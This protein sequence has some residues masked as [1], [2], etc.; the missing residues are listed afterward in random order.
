MECHAMADLD[1]FQKINEL[2][3]EEEQL[4]AS[5][6]DGSGLSEPERDR[7]EAIRVELD[8]T[9][10][11]LHQRQGRVDA[12]EDPESATVRSANVVENYEQ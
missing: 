11:L 1:L 7:L 3:Q 2:S 10:D 8:R 12:G 6:S 4:Y 5:A 9:Y